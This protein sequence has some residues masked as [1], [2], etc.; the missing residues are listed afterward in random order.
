MTALTETSASDQVML[1]DERDGMRKRERLTVNPAGDKG[2]LL[3][4]E[5]KE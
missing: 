1:R 4:R 3:Y 2:S 5:P